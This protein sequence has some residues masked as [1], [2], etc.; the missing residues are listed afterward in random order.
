MNDEDTKSSP[1]MIRTDQ[2]TVTGKNA[3]NCFID[4]YEQVSNIMIPNNRKQKVHDEIK[5]HQID[6]D[7]PE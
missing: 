2:E 1:V 6:Q 4:S 7:P 3:A 5:K